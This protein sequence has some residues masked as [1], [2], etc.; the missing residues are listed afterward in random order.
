MMPGIKT[1]NT[2]NNIDNND[3]MPRMIKTNR[4]LY[5]NCMFCHRR[6][7]IRNNIVVNHITKCIALPDQFNE[8]VKAYLERKYIK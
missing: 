6:I 7:R 1:I 5:A 2:I 4:L 8:T 3:I